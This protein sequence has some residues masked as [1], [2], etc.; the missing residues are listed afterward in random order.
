M[1]YLYGIGEEYRPRE[2]S[3]LFFFF[4]HAD[5]PEQGERGERGERGPE[6]RPQR[7]RY[8]RSPPGTQGERGGAVA[9]FRTHFD[10]S[11]PKPRDTAGRWVPT[12]PAPLVEDTLT[13]PAARL[14]ALVGR[15]GLRWGTVRWF[16]HRLSWIRWRALGLSKAPAVRL[17]W[18]ADGRAFSEAVKIG[19]VPRRGTGALWLGRCPGCDKPVGALYLAGLARWRCR[20]CVPRRYASQYGP[21]APRWRAAAQAI[22]TAS[23]PMASIDVQ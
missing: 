21:T 7:L 15:D 22:G 23:R 5:V 3:G 16:G 11:G 9:P 18:R 17:D 14:A 19:R 13:L 1:T 6:N 8:D 12:S 4:Q 2:Q 20:S 10:D